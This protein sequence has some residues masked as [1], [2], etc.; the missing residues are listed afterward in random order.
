[1]GARWRLIKALVVEDQSSKG[2]LDAEGKLERELKAW[3]IVMASHAGT[4]DESAHNLD[5]D[6]VND[7]LM[8]RLLDDEASGPTARGKSEF[9]YARRWNGSKGLRAVLA[10]FFIDERLEK[11]WR[12][13][14]RTHMERKGIPVHPEDNL[15]E[16]EAVTKDDEEE[17][18]EATKAKVLRYV[19]ERSRL[20]FVNQQERAQLNNGYVRQSS[21]HTEY[22]YSS[23]SGGSQIELS[24]ED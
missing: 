1:M 8:D 23:H 13:S 22:E 10:R 11:E 17:D 15:S 6:K 24:L 12:K 9:P 4:E 2:K 19:R 5:G 21:Q 3:F 20:A 7:V 18:D 14:W 16:P